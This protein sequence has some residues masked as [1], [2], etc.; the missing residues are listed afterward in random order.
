MELFREK[1]KHIHLVGIGGSGMS[2]IAEVLLDMGFTVSGSDLNY[3][4]S[5][6]RLANKGAKISIGHRAENL[7]SAD[8]VVVST[9]IKNDNPEVISAK[10]KGIPVIPRAEMLGELTRTK[11][12]I[13]IA[14][15]H[16]KTT[17]T[18][19]LGTILNF[20]DFNPTI[21][22]G[23][24]LVSLGSS[25]Q[26]GK[27]NYLIAEADESDKSFLHLFPTIAVITNIDREHLDCYT[28]IDDIKN[29]FLEFLRKIPFYGSA[30]INCDDTNLVEIQSKIHRKVL[31]YGFNKNANFR[32]E[33]NHIKDQREFFEIREFGKKIASVY[34]PM[35]GKHNVLNALA[36]FSAS[37]EIEIQPDIIKDALE[38][39]KGV[40]RRMEK[41]YSNDFT[42]YDDYGHHPTEIFYVLS[43]LK[44]FANPDRIITV[45]QP[46]RFSRTQKLYKELANSLCISNIVLLLDIYPASEK[47]V[48]GVTSELIYKTAKELNH[49]YFEYVRDFAE[50][51]EKLTNLLRKGDLLLFLGAGSIENF[52]REFVEH[53]K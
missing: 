45:F 40:H 32:A 12:S 14:G 37:R 44:R 25:A 36:S 11:F 28:D 22:D 34:L 7:K 46:H 8:V 31:T 3:N 39:Y 29:T 9:A 38:Q 47:P 33:N 43:S 52:A 4:D 18:A 53:L 26:H 24:K 1:I 30:I 19:M 2:G 10:E 50:T 27:G 21:I 20:A 42:I 48:E 35:W 16:G 41:L 5:I 49:P 6:S 17:T 13:L 15:M 23:G 51:K